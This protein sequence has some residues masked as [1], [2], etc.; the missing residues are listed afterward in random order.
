MNSPIPL[1]L[2]TATLLP[3]AAF[4]VILLTGPN[5]K[6]DSASYISIIA[7]LF[8]AVLSFASLGLWLNE[9]WPAGEHHAAHDDASHHAAT[10]TAHSLSPFQ[11]ALVANSK[12]DS[13]HP[14]ENHDDHAHHAPKPVISGVFYTL[15]QFGNLKMEFSYYIDSLTICMFCMVTLIAS[16]IHFYASGYMHDELHDIHDHEVILSNGQHLVR[17]GRYFRFFQYL[18]LFCFSMLGLVLAGNI[19][20]VFV[21]WELVGICS[22]FLIGFYIER[23]SAST[24]ANKAFIVNRVGDFGMIIGLL[25]LWSSLGTFS[26]SD[27]A[28][29]QPGLFSLVRS[30]ANHHALAV[31]DGMIQADAQA[32][33]AH[34]VSKLTDR[35]LENIQKAAN[36]KVA[37][38]REA[39]EHGGPRYGYWLLVVAGI[40]IFCGCVGKSAQ[41]PLHVW[42]PDAMEGPTPVSA[43]VHSATMV[44]AGVYL[45]GRFFPVFAP[46][47]LLVIA[48][49]GCITLFMAATIA[50]TAVD[51][52][53]VLAYSTVSQL[54]YM[55][56]SLGVGGWKA[57]LMHLVT[58]AFFKSLLFMCSGSVIHAVHTNDMRKMG[59]L[60]SKMPVTAITMLIGCLA[61]AGVGVPFVIGFS[62][63]YSKD[64]ILEQAYSLYL[65]NGTAYSGIF[66]IAAA[67]GAAITAFY[68]FRMWYMTFLGTPRD[69]E[70]FDHAHESPAV[71]TMPLVILSVFA[72]SVAW[73]FSLIG[74]ALI[75]GA[76]FI[77]RGLQQGWFKSTPGH[78]A[79][80][81]D[82]H[83]GDHHADEHAHASHGH[84]SPQHA[85]VHHDH[86]AHDMHTTH[87][88]PH[89]AHT[90]PF[91]LAWLGVMLVC[92]LLGGRLVETFLTS[93]AVAQSNFV[94]TAS[95]LSLSNL[96]EQARAE[97]TAADATG[98]WL[99]W[100]W[101]D[102]HKAHASHIVV[103]VTLLATGTWIFGI[104]LATLMY[105]LNV[106]NPEEVRRQ[107]QPIY[108]LLWNKW[109]FDELYDMIFVQPSHV[110]G[111]FIANIDKSWIDGLIHGIAGFTLGFS[112]IWERVADR[113]LIDGSINLFADWVYSFALQL[114][115][116]Q[117]GRLRQYVMFIVVGAL[118]V[119][120]LVSF[121]WTPAIAQ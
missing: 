30:A 25:A 50:I 111:R 36:H 68:M 44:A 110:L 14:A 96:L 19:A 46:E 29:G 5:L 6:K 62:G 55:M 99:A 61:I 90:P 40:G 97:G 2:L 121:F 115:L 28:D 20:L 39:A 45:V 13:E 83:D 70:K 101:P 26:F 57:G 79:A 15:G 104:G 22:Y 85:E 71:M 23:K 73:N 1:L 87:H 59:G 18:S 92:T 33:I 42:L 7:I 56:L 4:W 107:F 119:F 32:L 120:V 47:V 9:H 118:A 95:G 74:Y 24:A 52:K 43:L 60:L 3:F 34:D 93:S 27:S 38:L 86:H 117:T 106:L 100:T 64:A 31:P 103:P 80:H 84:E 72:I 76:F 41:F 75:A 94:Q 63:Y 112:R 67:G 89:T 114:R 21:F 78:H 12:A 10:K 109:W 66:F 102:E 49:S 91:T 37:E 65:T 17:P 77:A 51:I 82:H 54:G 69:Q 113:T 11:I 108:S 48:I 8:A 88:D 105:A 16:C 116:L 35:S 81:G 98:Y 53:R 58:H